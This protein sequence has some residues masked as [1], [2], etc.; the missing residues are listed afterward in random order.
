[1]SLSFPFSSACCIRNPSLSSLP[2]VTA[3]GVYSNAIDVELQRASSC[4]HR[5]EPWASP[6]TLP[7]LATAGG[8]GAA[9]G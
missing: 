8:D 4:A 1:M 6:E 3:A 2:L 9:W 5:V 7:Q